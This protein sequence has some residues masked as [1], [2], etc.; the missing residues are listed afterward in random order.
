MN[1]SGST[2]SMPRTPSAMAP[3]S[4][5]PSAPSGPS[6]WVLSSPG[7]TLNSWRDFES[8]EELSSLNWNLSQYIELVQKFE[9]GHQGGV[10]TSSCTTINVNIDRS[11]IGEITERYS[12]GLADLKKHCTQNDK[13]IAGLLSEIFKLESQIKLLNRSNSDKL[14]VVGDLE[15]T[16]GQLEGEVARLKASLAFYNGQKTIFEKRA[17]AFEEEIAGLTK[18]L[19][20]AIKELTGKRV[21]NAELSSEIYSLEKELRF[22]ISVLGRELVGERSKSSINLESIRSSKG[23]HYKIW[24]EKE[25]RALKENF[26]QLK[27]DAEITLE[28]NYKEKKES[29]EASLISA[30]AEA[31]KPDKE[32][33]LLKMELETLKLKLSEVEANS[34]QLKVKK[35]E[36]STEVEIRREAYKTQLSAKDR[37][38]ER[39]KA[40]HEKMKMKYDEWLQGI[41]TEQVALYSNTLTPEIRRISYRFGS[42]QLESSRTTINYTHNTVSATSFTTEGTVSNITNGNGV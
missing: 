40:E 3:P 38:L 10:N 42:E 19:E 1:R 12:E 32:S 24:M 20:S 39:L 9:G 2:D 33:T 13:I 14:S 26:E 23:E 27:A 7:K 8:S 5:P 25:L 41:N 36:I 17:K 18:R 31:D 34:Q 6:G 16:I 35:L 15:L 22:R 21:E 30:E 28:S 11:K 29:L 4:G 37:E